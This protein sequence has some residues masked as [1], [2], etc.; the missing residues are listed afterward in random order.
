[1]AIVI[2][3]ENLTRS[4]KSYRRTEGAWGAIRG[5][6]KRQAEIKEALKSTTLNIEG[7]QIVGL[8]GA[9]GAGKTTLLKLI[10]DLIRPDSGEILLGGKPARSQKHRFGIVLAGNMDFYPRM[11]ASQNLFYYASLY[12]C[13][14][15]VVCEAKTNRNFFKID[16]WDQPLEKLSSGMI[17]KL[18]IFR[19]FIHNPDIL[20]LDEPF[21]ALDNTSQA[22]FEAWL[23]DWVLA[24]KTHRAVV[25][26][27]GLKVGT[28]SKEIA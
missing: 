27:H 8:V 20:L 18:K 3:T 24:D 9:N 2:Q 11:T 23:K 19:A 5:F 17:Q 10:V 14:Q 21:N 6:F 13:G 15:K 4:Y 22:L 16:Y 28:V 12:D 26:Q 1:M 25:V 7:G